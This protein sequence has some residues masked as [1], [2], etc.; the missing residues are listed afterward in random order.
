MTLRPMYIKCP[1]CKKTYSWNPD[2]GKMMCPRCGNFSL[3]GTGNLP[4]E[5]PI[6]D[7]F[8]KKKKK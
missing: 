4:S 6:L 1:K 2:V 3:P 7:I 5:H 8:A